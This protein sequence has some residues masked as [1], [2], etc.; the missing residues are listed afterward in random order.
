MDLFGLKLK[1]SNTILADQILNPKTIT[2]TD[3]RI[4]NLIGGFEYDYQKVKQSRI[5]NRNEIISLQKAL[6]RVN[7][8]DFNTMKSIERTSVKDIR[9]YEKQLRKQIYDIVKN[10]LISKLKIIDYKVLDPFQRDHC[11]FV[12]QKR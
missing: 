4:S 5:K 2:N 6:E 8:L 10:K 9:S 1:L 12:C 3:Q 11:L 7:E